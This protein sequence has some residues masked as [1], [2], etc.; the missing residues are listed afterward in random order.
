M[1]AGVTSSDGKT[2]SPDC[3]RISNDRKPA[4]KKHIEA[5][6]AKGQ[7]KIP[8]KPETHH[9]QRP[10]TNGE[11]TPFQNLHGTGQDATKHHPLLPF[12][13]QLSGLGL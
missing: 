2:E 1:M 13:F 7:I 9:L 12:C 3:Q 4:V 8:A 11:H 6:Q 5:T 10:A